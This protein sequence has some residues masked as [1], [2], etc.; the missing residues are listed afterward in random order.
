MSFSS[1]QK[2]RIVNDLYKNSCCRRA[3]LGGILSSK[4]IVLKDCIEFSLEKTEYLDFASKLISEF[5]G[6]APEKFSPPK[7]GRCK[8]LRFDSKA[9]YKYLRSI[10]TDGDLFIPKCQ[11]CASAYFK[12]VFLS[13]GT[14]SDP[15]KQYLLEFHRKE[16]QKKSLMLLPSFPFHLSL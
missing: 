1:E 9:A 10:E 11:S 4:A 13:C 6:K 5:Y 8:I 15:R 14:I 16:A 7:G 2:L 3:L 12:G